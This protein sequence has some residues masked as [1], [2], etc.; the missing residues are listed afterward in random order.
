MISVTTS[1]PSADRESTR[2]VAIL[3]SEARPI[4]VLSTGTH[5]F[6]FQ[7]SRAARRN[8]KIVESQNYETVELLNCETTKSI[9]ADPPVGYRLCFFIFYVRLMLF[10]F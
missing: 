7:R 10:I 2:S 5:I 9:T 3:A 4:Y 6:A 8:Y 1:A